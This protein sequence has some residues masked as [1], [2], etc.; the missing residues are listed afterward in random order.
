MND[1]PRLRDLP[2]GDPLV[3]SLLRNAPTTR[4]PTPADLVR[5]GARVQAASTAGTTAAVTLATGWKVVALVG[6]VGLAALGV[7]RSSPR[8]PHPAQSPSAHATPPPR[9]VPAASPSAVGPSAPLLP[10]PSPSAEPVT[11]S[12]PVHGRPRAR[13]HLPAA[14]SS[15]A[16]PAS[17]PTLSLTDELQALDAARGQVGSDPTRAIEALRAFRG[18]QLRDERDALLAEALARAGRRDEARS[19]ATALLARHPHSPQGARVR[20][21]LGQAP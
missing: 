14:A 20:A 1:P 5:L 3:Q 13:R 15:H 10:P 17:E 4:P 11:L 18:T 9:P 12:A 16:A 7:H 2:Q 8:R 6:V 21:L 19:V